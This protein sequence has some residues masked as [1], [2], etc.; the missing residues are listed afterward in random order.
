MRIWPSTCILGDLWPHSR[1]APLNLLPVSCFVGFQNCFL[2]FIQRGTVFGPF[3]TGWPHSGFI[4]HN[5]SLRRGSTAAPR[6]VFN[7]NSWLRDSANAQWP[8][9]GMTACCVESFCF[10]TLQCQAQ[11]SHRGTETFQT[12]RLLCHWGM[13]IVLCEVCYIVDN[14]KRI[15][16]FIIYLK[17]CATVPRKADF[18]G[19][20]L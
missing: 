1:R 9:A 20:F 4:V 14:A 6:W 11:L 16:A 2:L 8:S 13:L 7:A 5:P 10:K 17:S 15:Y 3:Q 19:G 18:D 12:N